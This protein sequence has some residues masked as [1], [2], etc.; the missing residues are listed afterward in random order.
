M[1]YF[2]VRLLIWPDRSV[3]NTS[4]L[5]IAMS[6][7]R[8]YGRCYPSSRQMGITRSWDF[9]PNP[10]RWG[11]MLKTIAIRISNPLSWCMWV[12]SF[13]FDF[14]AFDD[15][16]AV[17]L[18]RWTLSSLENSSKFSFAVMYFELLSCWRRNLVMSCCSALSLLY[19]VQILFVDRGWY[20]AEIMA[21]H[22]FW[23][24]RRVSPSR[25]MGDSCLVNCEACEW[26]YSDL[27]SGHWFISA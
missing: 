26:K 13:T 3:I 10:L 14:G 12:K 11:I 18:T 24:W 27:R 4:L 8:K 21:S 16:M 2:P 20:K 22:N 1:M 9:G 23:S 19:D 15:E 17:Y 7:R 5:L 25:V 6:L